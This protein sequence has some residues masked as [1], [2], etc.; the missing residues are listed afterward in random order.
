MIARRTALKA[1][2]APWLPLLA[3]TVARPAWAQADEAPAPPVLQRIAS[4]WRVA[5]ATAPDSG[6]RVGL[7]QV[8]WAEGRVQVLA[9]QAVPSRAHG[10]LP[11]ADGGFLAVA[12]RP[13][14]WLMRCDAQGAVVQR[15][16]TDH[17]RPARTFNGHVETSADSQWLYTTETDPAT[18]AGWI[19][20]RDPQT[21]ARVAEFSSHGIDPHQLLR[22]PGAMAGRLMVAVGGI[23]RDRL[24]RKLDEPMEPA[25]VQ[26]D[27]STGALLGRWTLPDAQLSLRHIAWAQHP[28]PRLGVALQAEHAQPALRGAAPVLAVWEAD[29]RGDG[30]HLALRGDSAAAVAQSGGYAGDIAAGPGG[31]F[32]LSAQKQGRALWW[33]PSLPADYTTV[34]QVTEPC[35][36][37]TLPD[38]RGVALS[39]GRGLALWH[40]RAA[41]RMLAWPGVRVPDNHWVALGRA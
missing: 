12:N 9:E 35:G 30:G 39:A 23:V 11:L 18:G 38:G 7:L 15:I 19:S 17:E 27:A 26:L 36:L 21:L 32:V 2:Q 4:A 33:H 34:A 3:G 28:L 1:L 29:A 40:L 37:L 25:L 13:G 24:G 22:G 5:G 31:G 10:L 6:D 16:T 20:V 14:R 8:H 41:P